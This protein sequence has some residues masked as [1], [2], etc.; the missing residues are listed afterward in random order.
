MIADLVTR[1]RLSSYLAASGGDVDA[2]IALYDWNIEASGAVLSLVSIVEVMARNALDA[3]LSGW[4]QRVHGTP[5]W[6]DHV[7]LDP[8]GRRDVV[9]A[10]GRAVRRQPSVVHGKVVAELSLGFW[11]YL[12]ASRYL[13]SLWVPALHHAFPYGVADARQR[14]RQVELR[15]QRLAFVRNRAAHHEPIHQRV[16]LDDVADA[17]ALVGWVSPDGAEWVRARESVTSVFSRRPN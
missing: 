15:L 8:R 9:E 11:R 2:A 5:E 3:Q 17:L 16:L 12:A 7:P 4:S 13:T 1:Q 14:R 6:F 10:R